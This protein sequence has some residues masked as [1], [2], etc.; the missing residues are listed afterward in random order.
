MNRTDNSETAY[1]GPFGS[2]MTSSSIDQ[3]LKKLLD[4]RE[5]ERR[6]AAWRAAKPGAPP[7]PFS[8][9]SRVRVNKEMPDRCGDEGVIVKLPTGRGRPTIGRPPG[10]PQWIG[11]MLDGDT[12]IADWHRDYFDPVS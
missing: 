5:T 9:G 1:G 3:R 2:G 10:N 4:A 11:V 8:L 12:E 7:S 6:L